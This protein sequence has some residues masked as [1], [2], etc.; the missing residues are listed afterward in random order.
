MPGGNIW[1]DKKKMSSSQYRLVND[2]YGNLPIPNPNSRFN[3]GRFI[4]NVEPAVLQEMIEAHLVSGKCPDRDKTK[5]K[6]LVE[7]RQI[8]PRQTRRQV[9]GLTIEDLSDYKLLI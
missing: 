5:L 4:F 9:S 3:K 2:F 6:E 1:V 8:T 7:T